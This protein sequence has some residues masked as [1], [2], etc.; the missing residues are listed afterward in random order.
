LMA[1][2]REWEKVGDVPGQ[3]QSPFNPQF[4]S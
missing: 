3:L 4:T 1:D 2:A